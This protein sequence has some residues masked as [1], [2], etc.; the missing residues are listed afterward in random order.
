VEG[1]IAHIEA[2]LTERERRAALADQRAAKAEQ[3]T[4]EAKQRASKARTEQ[5]NERR[6][7]EE[8]GKR[9]QVAE[10]MRRQEEEEKRRQDEE[11][12]RRRQ[13]E[14]NLARRMQEKQLKHEEHR[15]TQA[16]DRAAQAEH[17]AALAEKDHADALSEQSLQFQARSA[18][19]AL[20]TPAS[21]VMFSDPCVML[22]RVAELEQQIQQHSRTAARLEL[23]TPPNCGGGDADHA[24]L[25]AVSTSTAV[26]VLRAL[27]LEPET[28]TTHRLCGPP[29]GSCTLRLAD[30]GVLAVEPPTGTIVNCNTFAT[31]PNCASPVGH[32]TIGKTDASPP[33]IHLAGEE[34]AT[35]PSAAGAAEVDPK[36]P[37]V[38]GVRL[39]ETPGIAGV[40]TSQA[41]ASAAAAGSGSR[42]CG[43]NT[44]HARGNVHEDLMPE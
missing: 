39:A 18:A 33:I 27:L 42:L 20:D 17:R 22:F 38:E 23:A 1:Q 9:R 14:E 11:T 43:R 2:L 31:K 13:E 10:V 37:N 34:L 21:R 25:L 19:V 6:R 41:C 29:D 30:C 35:A 16:E 28:E 12:W 32:R 8:E 3:R 40:V 24:A 26:E 4:A 5:A 44:Q 7:H 36:R 15:A